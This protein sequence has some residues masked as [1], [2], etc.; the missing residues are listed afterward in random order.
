ML[1]IQANPG[2][3]GALSI[4][5]GSIGAAGAVSDTTGSLRPAGPSPAG[6]A[7]LQLLQ[8]ESPCRLFQLQRTWAS[9]GMGPPLFSR[10][11]MMIHGV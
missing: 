8:Q 11:S 4:S 5:S 3:T 2:G 9:E 10:S 1:F 7:A 6:L